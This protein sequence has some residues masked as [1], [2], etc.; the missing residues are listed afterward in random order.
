MLAATAPAG[1][2]PRMRDVAARYP[3]ATEAHSWDVDVGDLTRDGID[4]LVVSYHGYVVFYRTSP[5]HRIFRV[6]GDDPHACAIADVNLDGLGDVYC[7]RGAAIGRIAKGNTLW[8]HRRGGGFVDRA[9]RYGVLD[10]YGRGRHTTFFDLNG[11][12]YPDLF[13]GNE[14]PRQDDRRSWNRTFANVAGERFEEVTVG[15]TGAI[16]ALCAIAGDLDG[17]EWGDLAVCGQD[18]L[19]LYR[20]RWSA[21]GGRELHDVAPSWGLDLPGVVSVALVDSGGTRGAAFAVVRTN[22]VGIYRLR[23]QGVRRTFRAR[24]SHGRWAAWGDLDGRFGP[25]LFVVRGCANGAN[26]RDVVFLDRGPGTGYRTDV[27]VP[28][29]GG[30][31]DVAV[32]I[33]L[34]LD[35]LD[36]IVVLNGAV[37][38][39]PNG[40][41][42][43]PVQVLTSAQP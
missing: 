42:P 13:V 43:G 40:G 38:A 9:F 19:R 34:D 14:F 7:T 37:G 18:R 41:V 29:A 16:G 2:D 10:R 4:D 23:P 6:A 11:D 27:R 1:A 28:S 20:N 31:G 17:D 36:E 15:A 12:P 33:D 5:V 39:P 25:D 30:C 21:D 24:V 35:G 26:R 8:L 3:F 22:G 32:A